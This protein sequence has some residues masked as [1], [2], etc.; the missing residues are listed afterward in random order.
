MYIYLIF[1]NTDKNLCH[2]N[3]K[4]KKSWVH[5]GEPSTSTSPLLGKL[6]E[7]KLLP[8][9]IFCSAKNSKAY[10]RLRKM[11]L[12]IFKINVSCTDGEREFCFL[13]GLSAILAFASVGPQLKLP[14]HEFFIV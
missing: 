12:P 5:P 7:K 9:V 13:T 1:I 11:G 14:D 10:H 4:R 6:L 2:Y 3:S 8:G